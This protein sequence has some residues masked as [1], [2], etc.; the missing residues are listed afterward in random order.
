MYRCEYHVSET[1]SVSGDV[2]QLMMEAMQ[3]QHLEDVAVA[4]E[5][6]R[7]RDELRRAY[8]AELQRILGEGRL[9][10]YHALRR[11]F[12]GTGA[13]TSAE[14]AENK[15]RF[16]EA[17]ARQQHELQEA[18][19]DSEQVRQLQ[20]RFSQQLGEAQCQTLGRRPAAKRPSWRG[21]T[22]R[23]VIE[24]PYLAGYQ[25]RS[26][27]S[28]NEPIL[29]ES[30]TNESYG[31]LRMESRA[32]IRYAGDKEVA[33]VETKN[34]C[35]VTIGPVQC[36]RLIIHG[37]FEVQEADKSAIVVDEYGWSGADVKQEIQGIVSC[38]DF[39]SNESLTAQTGL[40]GSETQEIH[41]KTCAEWHHNDW[42]L[43]DHVSSDKVEVD[44]PFGE[45][46]PSYVGV[47]V[48]FVTL[49]DVRAN[50]V[51]VYSHMRYNLRLYRI[52]VQIVQD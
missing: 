4:A 42:G 49:N 46:Y 34:W 10:E 16:S 11:Q 47:S 18:G 17:F 52:V 51:T 14:R 36:K 21:E 9:D 26:G 40:P 50:D 25:W 12:S 19:V 15:R 20:R 37:N 38:H 41:D 5:C 39:G 24:P 3:R 27:H 48:G 32:A 23:L 33:W 45:P 44:G 7:V 28:T 8:G 35:S 1:P 29:A 22:A 13:S 6:R 2:R 43:W 30:H 31:R